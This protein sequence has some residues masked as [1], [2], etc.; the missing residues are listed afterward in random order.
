MMIPICIFSLQLR[1]CCVQLTALWSDLALWAVAA[2]CATAIKA[3]MTRSAPFRQGKT[4]KRDEM[5]WFFFFSNGGR[6][7]LVERC[8]CRFSDVNV[9]ERHEIMFIN[10][11]LAPPWPAWPPSNHRRWDLEQVC[12]H[13]VDLLAWTQ[14]VNLKYFSL[15]KENCCNSKQQLNWPFSQTYQGFFFPLPLLWLCSTL[16][17]EQKCVKRYVL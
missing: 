8:M 16:P 10:T 13:S 7:V 9:T 15:I 12:G 17:D 14:S 5:M 3:E 2:L 6:H 1:S 4:Q 11:R